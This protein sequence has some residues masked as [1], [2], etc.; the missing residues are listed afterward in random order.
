MVLI[1]ESEVRD[2]EECAVAP[3][4]KERV[5]EHFALSQKERWLNYLYPSESDS[6]R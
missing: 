2:E 6:K 4:M 1:D 5:G 3:T